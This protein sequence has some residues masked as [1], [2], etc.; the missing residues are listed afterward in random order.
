MKKIFLSVDGFFVGLL[1]CGELS[2]KEHLEYDC[3]QLIGQT[4][5][6]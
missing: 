1:N 6:L 2:H 4:P 3:S 5:C